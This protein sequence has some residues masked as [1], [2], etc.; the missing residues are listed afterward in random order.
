MP[1]DLPRHRL[2]R[3]DLIDRRTTLHHAVHHPHHPAR[4]FAARRALPAAFMLVELAEPGDR[5]DDVGRLVHH[6]NRRRAETRLHFAQTVEI[7]QDGVAGRLVQHRHR[8]AA[9]DHREQIVPAPAHPAGIFLD[10]LLERN[11]KLLFDIAGLVHMPRNAE[12]LGPGILRPPQRREPRGPAPQN[13]RRHRDAL[14]VVH[15]GRAPVKP[16]GSRKWRLQ[17]R[18]PLLALKA[19]DQRGFLAANIGPGAA[20]QIAVEIPPGAAGI[21]ADQSGLVGLV[22]RRL[23]GHCLVVEFAADID[24]AGMRPHREGRDEAA[25]DQLVRIVADDVAILAG[26]GLGLI[27]IHHQIMRQRPDR[28]G[29]ERPFH[30]GREPRAAAPAQARSLHLLD[31]RLATALDDRLGSVPVAA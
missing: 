22:D 16:H 23:Q 30:P 6:D 20:M 25:L 31:D 27:G 19:L 18:H 13:R 12:Q 21:L 28:L 15:R 5:L 2:Q 26:A 1:L 29:H 14:D 8:R 3:V 11:A 24:V 4:S 17:P 9:R 10:Q 7:H